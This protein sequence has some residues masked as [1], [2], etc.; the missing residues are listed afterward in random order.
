MLRG[1]MPLS[2]S[3]HMI[4]N[5]CVNR[6]FSSCPVVVSYVA[7]FVPSHNAPPEAEERRFTRQTGDYLCG[8]E[9]GK[10][11]NRKRLPKTTAQVVETSVT[12]NNRSYSGIQSPE[13]S[14][15]ALWQSYSLKKKK[16]LPFSTLYLHFLVFFEVWK[17]RLCNNAELRKNPR[18]SS[19]A[20]LN[21]RAS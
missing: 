12:T 18:C 9:N 15:D 11:R 10:P 19:F 13:I 21:D 3:P 2:L 1:W 8:R 17:S 20:L 5:R 6:D 7:V 4:P 16:K 14:N